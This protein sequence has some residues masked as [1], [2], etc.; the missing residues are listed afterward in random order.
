MGLLGGWL[1]YSLLRVN[2]EME[3]GSAIP[4]ERYTFISPVSGSLSYYADREVQGSPLVLLHS[5]NAAAS[6]YEVR[7]LFEHYREMRPV[8]ALDLPGF[9]FSDRSRRRYTPALYAQSIIDFV[10]KQVP[11]PPADVVAL[12]LA[13]EFAAL[14]ALQRPDLIRSLT[15]ISPTGMG[16]STPLSLK[17]QDQLYG[18]LN[19]PLW[20]QAMFDLLTS[21]PSLRYFLKQSFQGAVNPGL[22][23]Y[24]Y[25]TAHQPGAKHAPLQFVSG[26]L[27]TPNPI[28]T[29]WSKLTIPVHVIYD[30]D[31][32]VSFDQLPEL[33]TREQWSTTQIIPT[34]GLPHFE[35]L[36]RV[37]AALNA[38]W[39]KE[40]VSS[41]QLV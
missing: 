4:A 11:R 29:L 14:V 25:L 31:P 33:A 13:G 39:T 38:F 19:F 12:S 24:A 21:R 8:Y 5:V 36:E 40:M 9:G 34:R 23:R 35:Q 2:H 3:I 41:G 17:R 15:L 27:F 1:S 28:E 18:W 6:S 26:K 16:Y 10:E 30:R 37:T 7:P 32:N 22:E 20:S